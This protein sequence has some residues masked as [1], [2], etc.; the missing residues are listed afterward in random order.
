MND[1]LGVNDMGFYEEKPLFEMILP[2]HAYRIWAGGRLEGFPKERLIINRMYPLLNHGKRLTK[3]A[4][5]NGLLT[6][7]QRTH[8]LK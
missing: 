8:F 6:V 4:I 3:K 2:N 1:E 7:E 5:D